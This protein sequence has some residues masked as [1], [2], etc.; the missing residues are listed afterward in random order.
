MLKILPTSLTIPLASIDEK[1][2]HE[3]YLEGLA[4]V[5]KILQF[6][7]IKAA[8]QAKQTQN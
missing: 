4:K 2:A 5:A 6:G 7:I 8:E 1:E 3:T